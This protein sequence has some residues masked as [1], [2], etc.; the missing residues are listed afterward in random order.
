MWENRLRRDPGSIEKRLMTPEEVLDWFKS[1]RAEWSSRPKKGVPDLS[2]DT[3]LQQ[4]GQIYGAFVNLDLA[5]VFKDELGIEVTLELWRENSLDGEDAT[6]GDL[7]D[8]LAARVERAEVKPADILGR[9]C[10]AVGAFETILC[11]LADAGADVSNV[12]PSTL[13]APYMRRWCDVFRVEVAK[14]APLPPLCGLSFWVVG[15]ALMALLGAMVIIPG[16]G[17]G[18]R[19]LWV[20]GII[21][22]GLGTV[23]A[24]IG[25]KLPLTRAEYRDRS[26]TLRTFGDL[27]KAIAQYS[28]QVVVVES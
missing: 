8:F 28:S 6:F 10:A 5:D 9:P 21:T 27:A 15:G 24:C 14:L 20:P 18:Y 23:I 2:F 4:F 22:A 17:M 26:L 1:K 13:L 12:A 7:C 3:P 16:M 11:L 25:M 19:W